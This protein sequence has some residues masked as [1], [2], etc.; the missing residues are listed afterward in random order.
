MFFIGRTDGR[1]TQNYSSEPHKMRFTHEYEFESRDTNHI[2]IN[3]I[4]PFLSLDANI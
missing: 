3:K 1:S 4:E 2:L